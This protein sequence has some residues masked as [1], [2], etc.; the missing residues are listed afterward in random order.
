MLL[1]PFSFAFS[2]FLCCFPHLNQLPL[3]SQSIAFRIS[4]S[5]FSHINQ[6]L[7]AS[8][9]VASLISLSCC[10]YLAQFL[11]SYI[12][13]FLILLSLQLHSPLSVATHTCS[14]PTSTLLTCFSIL[15]LLIRIF[16]SIA[17]QTSLYYFPCSSWLFLPAFNCF[18]LLSIVSCNSLSCFSH[19]S[20]LLLASRS[21]AS[22]PSF[23]CLSILSW[24]FLPSLSVASCA[25]FCCFLWFYLKCFSYL[26]QLLHAFA[27]LSLTQFSIVSCISFMCFLH[28]VHMRL[29]AQSL[30]FNSIFYF[31]YLQ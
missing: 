21:L 2:T 22:L 31:S 9:L 27:H 11:L 6:L 5:C 14:V 10:S 25:L 28:I 8:Q 26:S 7:L 20:S 15:F 13:I 18:S 23:S 12:T 19:L 17:S 3:I 16:L 24:L 1:A 30:A 4:M 29:P